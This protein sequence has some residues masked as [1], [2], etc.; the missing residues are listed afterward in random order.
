MNSTQGFF[1]FPRS[2]KK[3][4]EVQKN[5]KKKKRILSQKVIDEKGNERRIIFL[6]SVFFTLFTLP[7]FPAS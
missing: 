2:A 6:I 4:A 5:V 7:S 1:L 3:F